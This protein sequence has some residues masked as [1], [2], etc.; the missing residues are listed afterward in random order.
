MFTNEVIT[1]MSIE[2]VETLTEKPKNRPEDITDSHLGCLHNSLVK[3]GYLTT[4]NLGGYELTWQGRNAILR[5]T[6][7]LLACEDAAW[8]KDRVE[9]LGQLYDEISH[10]YIT[11]GKQ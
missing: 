11:L 2:G 1:L 6:I 5:E 8:V 9:R 10:K 7:M 3:R 4:S